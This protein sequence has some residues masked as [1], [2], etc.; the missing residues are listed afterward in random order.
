MISV[1]NVR[2]LNA[3]E[4]KCDVALFVNNSK[5]GK[6]WFL[7]TKLTK[8]RLLTFMRSNF[9]CLKVWI[10]VL[11]TP[12]YCVWLLWDR[13][14]YEVLSYSMEA[15]FIHAHVRWE[16]VMKYFR[17]TFVYAPYD[18][19]SRLELWEKFAGLKASVIGA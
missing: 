8:E 11:Y 6:L 14:L 4:K 12:R 10:L 13:G 5:N 17:L 18:F 7:E 16:G 15:S 9:L 1:W 2:D 19:A 3:F